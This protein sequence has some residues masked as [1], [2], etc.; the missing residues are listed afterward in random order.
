[1]TEKHNLQVGELE[2]NLDAAEYALVTRQEKQIEALKAENDYLKKVK[3][4]TEI[5]NANLRQRNDA[6]E[7]ENQ[8]LQS[9]IQVVTEKYNLQVG[10][11]ES[12][13]DA[14]K[15]DVESIKSRNLEL[16]NQ[17]Y[18]D[19]QFKFLKVAGITIM[20]VL[21][22][23][24]IAYNVGAYNSLQKRHDEIQERRDKILNEN[25]DNVQVQVDKVINYV[26]KH[27][28]SS[29]I[30]YPTSVSRYTG[31]DYDDVLSILLK[32]EKR[33]I[34]TK[35]QFPGVGRQPQFQLK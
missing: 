21:S 7:L 4:P 19:K 31:V 16:I 13:L 32:L 6:L 15:Q 17:H 12:N 24:I 14:A 23:S 20:A 11:L 18:K 28:S 2:S 9:E 33:G 10:E 27:E 1:M 35:S 30:I 34:V 5:E 8:S 3:N 22:A 25:R 29:G 26:F